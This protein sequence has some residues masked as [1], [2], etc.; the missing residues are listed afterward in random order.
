MKLPVGLVAFFIFIY[1]SFASERL[2]LAVLSSGNPVEEYKRF[3]ALS[4]YLSEKLG[5]E[6][7]LKIF[8]KYKDLLQFYEENTVDIS[9]SCPVVYYKIQEKH[10]V[11]PAAV[12]KIKGHVMEAGVIVVRK[13]SNIHSVQDIKGKK[14]TLGSSIC[15]SNCIMP[16]YILSKNGIKYTD[17][18]DM[19]SSGSDKAAILSVISGLADAAG[20]KEESAEKFLNKG[21]KIIAKSPYVPRYVVA[22]HGDLPKNLQKKIMEILYSLRDK[23]TLNRLG[24]DGFEKPD[25][26]MFRIIKDYNDILSQ[27][28]LLQ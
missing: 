19:W 16:L 5:R 12:I 1:S 24:I 14:L 17:I 6:I 11:I 22:I 25:K 18:P 23:K 13:D 7:Q 27:Y 28:P 4:S 8:G 10:N 9:I 2:I 20:V 21:I 15:A 3:K 26:D